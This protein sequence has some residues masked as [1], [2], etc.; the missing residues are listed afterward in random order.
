MTADERERW[1]W[2]TGFRER[3]R[4]EEERE[5][6]LPDLDSG[7]VESC[8]AVERSVGSLLVL[9]LKD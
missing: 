9:G 4:R 3:E 7:V 1:D 6:F 8:A 2:P 5:G